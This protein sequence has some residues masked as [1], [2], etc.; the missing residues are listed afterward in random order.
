MAF[1]K[2]YQRS[3]RRA[4]VRLSSHGVLT[5][6]QATAAR[7]C[8]SAGS[9]LYLLYHPEDGRIALQVTKLD[10]GAAKVGQQGNV[11]AISARSFQSRFGI[12]PG[13]FNA[14]RDLQTGLIVCR[15]AEQ[16]A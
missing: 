6:N 11:L 5:L 9:Y 4:E 1:I 2:H 16:P 13:K 8:I 15:R 14:E 3:R 7:F 12:A 10:D